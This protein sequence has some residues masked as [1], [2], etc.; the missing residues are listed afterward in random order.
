MQN[1]T[2]KQ[3]QPPQTGTRETKTSDAPQAQGAPRSGPISAHGG[4]KDQPAQDQTGEDQTGKDQS[5]KA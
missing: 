2:D 4:G 3:D 5:S 1:Q